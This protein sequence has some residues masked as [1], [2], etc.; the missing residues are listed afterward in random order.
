MRKQQSGALIAMLLSLVG[1]AICAHLTYLHLAL[2]R[3]EIVGGIGCGA[4]G[5]VFNCH[6]VTASPFGRFLDV[7]LSLWGLLGYLVAFSLALIAWQLPE[8]AANALAGLTLLSLGFIT[9]DA[10]LFAVMATQ[11]HHFCPLC[12]ATYAVNLLMLIIAKTVSAKPWAQITRSASTLA[13][14]LTPPRRG[15]AAG[16]I[17]W[18]IVLTGA[19]GVFSVNG[20]VLYMARGSPAAFRKQ[21]AEF[22][23]QRPRVQVDTTGDPV[24]G[25]S[26]GAIQIVEF[27]DFLCPSC[28][29]AW[30]FN[31][32]L[33]AG[34]MHEASFAF[35]NFP[36]DST[37]NSA[38][39]RVVH[40]GACDVAAAAECAHEQGKFWEFQDLA[41]KAGPA[42]KASSIDGDAASLGLDMEKFHA[43]QQSGRGIEA[44]KRDIAQAVQINVTRTPTYVING[45]VIEGLVNPV[46]F[47]ELIET[48]RK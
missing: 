28:Q 24:M 12:L 5:S 19:A 32:I 8:R 30:S 36:L 38:L 10:G 13:T 7:P 4:A 18:G 40:A 35:K 47:E 29:R 14:E 27:S 37:C 26:D 6:V 44:V 48:V 2:L 21:L 42:Y 43:C 1:I 9:M 39:N 25:A 33:L 46:M 23:T 31:P 41:F 22:T 34:H 3:G 15:S 20:S 11:L 16:W 45:V 17:F